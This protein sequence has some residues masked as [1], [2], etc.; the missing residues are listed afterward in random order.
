L[1]QKLL[2]GQI[3]RG[4]GNTA[5]AIRYIVTG[6]DNRTLNYDEPESWYVPSRE[7]SEERYWRTNNLRKRAGI[8]CGL[9]EAPA[10]IRG[11]LYGLWEALIAQ[12]K[13]DESRAGAQ[14]S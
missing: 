2:R 11:S 5:A 10:S 4:Q 7:F 1:R 14:R 6:S 12:N 8:S 9:G 13:K 3:A